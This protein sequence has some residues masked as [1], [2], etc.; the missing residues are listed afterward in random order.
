M[1][2]ARAFLLLFLSFYTIGGSSF[3][4]EMRKLTGPRGDQIP[5]E[6]HDT[7]D[8]DADADADASADAI[9]I[10]KKRGCRG[11]KKR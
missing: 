8:A 1:K 10:R 5:A 9:L 7:N 2:K 11:V 4:V 3:K 6:K